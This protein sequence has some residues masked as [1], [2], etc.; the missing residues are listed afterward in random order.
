MK[1]DLGRSVMSPVK[2]FA[3]EFYK[4][5][6]SF[7]NKYAMGKW[8]DTYKNCCIYIG[9][10]FIFYNKFFLWNVPVIWHLAIGLPIHFL[11][12]VLIK[13]LPNLKIIFWYVYIYTYIYI[14]IYAFTLRMLLVDILVLFEFLLLSGL[15]IWWISIPGEKHFLKMKI[16]ENETSVNIKNKEQK[17]IK[18][19]LRCL[20]KTY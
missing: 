18:W 7:C 17:E 6:R 19:L 10:S 12:R 4:L 16:T 14:Y 13:A 2:R 20:E 11:A 3:I 5:E 8:W 9:R 15:I 1:Q